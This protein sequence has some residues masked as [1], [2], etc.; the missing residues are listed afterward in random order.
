M[1][2]NKENGALF[3]N[4]KQNV[5]TIE[6]VEL[7]YLSSY[8]ELIYNDE[9]LVI[10]QRIFGKEVFIHGEKDSI[11]PIIN[12]LNVGVTF[13][14]LAILVKNHLHVNKPDDFI[15]TCMQ[16]GVIE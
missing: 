7:L 5:F 13:D 3:M 2:E 14:D 12:A 16:N 6:N 8:S 11:E 9:G 10:S 15:Y 1:E 4:V